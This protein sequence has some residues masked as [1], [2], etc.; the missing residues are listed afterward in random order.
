MSKRFIPLQH[1]L[2]RRRSLLRSSCFYRCRSNHR[3]VPLP[4]LC[5]PGWRTAATASTPAGQPLQ[6]H[7]CFFKLLSFLPQIG[8]NLRDVH[9]CL[10][11]STCSRSPRHP[12]W[13]FHMWNINPGIH[14]L[15]TIYF[16]RQK[17]I[18]CKLIVLISERCP[19]GRAETDQWPVRPACGVSSRNKTVIPAKS[20]KFRLRTEPVVP[21]K[22]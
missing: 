18:K 19:C 12:V 21:G 17:S 2:S 13:R 8:K 22:C 16:V 9:E 20:I 1:P 15:Y 3:A 7:D 4:G 10:Q 5:H 11:I 6:T 14:L